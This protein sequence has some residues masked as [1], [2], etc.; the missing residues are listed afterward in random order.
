MPLVRFIDYCAKSS[1]E[2]LQ[3]GIPKWFYMDN[4]R[5]YMVFLLS[6]GILDNLF[7][8]AYLSVV[9]K[10][11]GNRMLI[12]PWD[13]DCS[14]GGSWNGSYY[15]NPIW[16][17][18][19]LSAELPRRLWEGNVAGFKGLVYDRWQA[20]RQTV[21]SRRRSADGSMPTPA[22]LRSREHGNASMQSGMAIQCL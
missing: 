15:T 10:S 12:T 8:N 3:T 7:K 4:L 19:I 14:L 9:D 1:N 17:G 2:Q 21:L 16:E 5:D 6:Q 20:L 18:F 11:K 13:L 22:C